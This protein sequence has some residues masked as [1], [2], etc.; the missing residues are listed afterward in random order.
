MSIQILPL[1]TVSEVHTAS[2]VLADVWG[3][4]RGG[5]PP[6]LLRALAHAGNYAVGL[7]DEGRMVAASVAFFA[8]PA[9]R[10]MHSHITGV[11]PEYQGR[12][13]GRIIKSH[14]REWALAR[15]VGH[16]TWTFDPLV[17][18][19][20]HFNL[21]VLGARVTEYLVDHYGPMDD[22][23]NRGDET[24]RI[25]VSW[26]LASPPVATPAED[27][28][29]TTVAIPRDIE[30]LRRESPMEAADWRFR[31]REEILGLLQ[32]GLVVGGFDARGYLITRA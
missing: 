15:D 22:G 6:N 10:S 11:L 23:V 30:A 20:A 27:R 3:G 12:G 31:V 26:A 16:I 8:A 7:Y 4:D 18:R 19:N 5:M 1:D 14:Q 13:L 2:Q 21:R 24:D 17:A 28:V 29:V 32:D 9:Q 25:M